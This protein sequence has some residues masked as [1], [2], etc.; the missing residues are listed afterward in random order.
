MATELA[1]NIRQV[2]KWSI[3]W[4]IALIIV[5]CV[6][7]A[8][9]LASS[10]AAALMVGWLVFIGGLVQLGHAFQST[11]IGHIA[12]KLLVAAFYFAVGAYLLAHPGMGLAALTLM[13]AVFFIAQGAVDITAWFSTRTTNGSPWMLINGI[14]S[15]ILGFTVWGRWPATSLWFV[16]TLVGISLLMA[17]IARLMMALAVRKLLKDPG[18]SPF[19]QP[20]AA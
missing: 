9:P 11:G 12:W 10:L 6:A 20:R 8:L 15:F 3:V 19:Q 5:G 1:A 14:I 2:S 4:S 16:G 7:L 17:G 13:I 18:T